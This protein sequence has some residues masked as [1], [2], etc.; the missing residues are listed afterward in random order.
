MFGHSVRESLPVD[1]CVRQL[2]TAVNKH[3]MLN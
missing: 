2:T 3:N 1:S